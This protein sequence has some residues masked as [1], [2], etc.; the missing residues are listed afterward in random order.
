MSNPSASGV[1]PAVLAAARNTQCGNPDDGKET[2][3]QAFESGWEPPVSKSAKDV[4]SSRKA[5]E[6]HDFVLKHRLPLAISNELLKLVNQV[7]HHVVC[8]ILYN[9][10]LCSALHFIYMYIYLFICIYS[11]IYH[12]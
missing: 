8:V 12:V 3:E 1:D 7:I 5:K 6:V 9:H 11:H 10:V 4:Y 2:L